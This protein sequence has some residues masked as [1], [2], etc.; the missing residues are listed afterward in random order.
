MS[1]YRCPSCDATHALFAGDALALIHAAGVRHVWS[2]DCIPHST[3]AVA[4]APAIAATL[5]A[6][7]TEP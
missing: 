3:N 2:T 5:T 7:R 6:L 4:M 1:G